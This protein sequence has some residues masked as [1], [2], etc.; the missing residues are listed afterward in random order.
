MGGSYSEQGGVRVD[1]LTLA[2]RQPAHG[3][4]CQG[5]SC[6][7][8]GFH[9]SMGPSKLDQR[10]ASPPRAPPLVSSTAG[11]RA[12]HTSTK[13]VSSRLAQNLGVEL[14]YKCLIMDNSRV[15]LPPSAPSQASR[16]FGLCRSRMWAVLYGALNGYLTCERPLLCV[17]IRFC[18]VRADHCCRFLLLPLTVMIFSSGKKHLV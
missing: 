7:A 5:T 1:A 10:R 3:M 6:P 13:C 12:L 9:P 15:F 17:M 16:K 18:R 4:A 14:V 2:T 11:A 8:R